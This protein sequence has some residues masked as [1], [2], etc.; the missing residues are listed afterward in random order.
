M[1]SCL[2]LAALGATSES[3]DNKTNAPPASADSAVASTNAQAAS[4]TD[5]S[6]SG[7]DANKSSEPAKASTTNESATATAKL[8]DAETNGA[9]PRKVSLTKVKTSGSKPSD[10]KTDSASSTNEIQVSFQGA[11]IDMIAQWLS[12]QTGK[13]VVKHPQVQC[14][15]TIMSSKKVPPREAINLV[16]RALALEGFTAVESSSSIFLV[17]EGKEPKFNPELLDGAKKDIPEGR[18]RLMKIFPLAHM[19]ANEIREKLRPL[20]SERGTIDIDERANQ[21]VV[22]DYNDN[23]RLLA[24]VIREFDVPASGMTVEIYPLKFADAE[25]L[26][27][28]ITLILNAQ[29]AP[30][31]SARVSSPKGSSGPSGGPMGISFGGSPPSM[32]SGGGGSSSSPSGSGPLV[33]GQVRIWPDKNSNRLIVFA[34]KSKLPEVQRL[35]DVLDTEKPEDVAVRMIPLKNVTAGDLAR[36]LA[37]LYQKMSGKSQKEMIEIAADERSNSLIVL[38]SEANFKTIQK[39]VNTLDTEEAQEKT[40]RTFPLKNADAEDVARQ[41]QDLNKD[42]D[43]SNSPYRFFYFGG[44][45]RNKGVS[46]K[47]SVVADRRRNSLIIQAPPAQMDSIEKIIGEL[48]EPVTDDSLAP[49]IY[50]LKYVSAVDIEDVL[51]ELFLKKTQQRSYWD[52]YSDYPSENTDRDVGRL[53]GKVRITAEPYS[54]TIIVTS[55]SKES[56]AVIE[57]VLKQLDAPSEANESTLRINLKFAKAPVVANAINILFAKNGSPQI[58]PDNQQNQQQQQNYQQQQQQGSSP[59]TTTGFELEKETKLDIYYPWI[60]GQPDNPRTADGRTA[61]RAVSDLVG[62]V[63]VVPDQRSNALLISANVHFFPQIIKMIE[64]LDAETDQVLI[65]ARLVEVSS[66]YLDKLG[67]RWSPD[68]TVF[69]GDDLE[70]SFIVNTKGKYN[71]STGPNS[72]SETL[73]ELRSGVFSSTFSVDFLI[74][75]L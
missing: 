20:L 21:L 73:S 58:K 33:A 48:D 45:D 47:M 57:D 5:S 12:Q 11:N 68:G 32:D 72:L 28:L 8:E 10:G 1:L 41:L 43:N 59:T 22:T 23:L 2:L 7:S 51:N 42:Q 34:P 69:T 3:D 17:P 13:S 56:L 49:K 71:A 25:E 14:Q 65:D 19:Q 75:F 70:N 35:I 61:V 16:Y 60:G 36:E 18:Q 38:S 31:G 15:L 40:V 27:S 50:P 24:Q 37:Q 62:R 39:L 9:S 26:G 66:D 52:Y 63:R 64:E 30:P 54:N 6:S 44:M 4:P 46:R 67:V 55:N 29:P 53:Y 74:Q